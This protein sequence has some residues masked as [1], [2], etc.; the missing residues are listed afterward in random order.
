MKRIF[1]LAV[2][3]FASTSLFAQSVEITPLFGYTFS[4]HVNGYY[5]E[6]DVK[7]DIMYGA[8]LDVEFDHLI[9]FEASYRRVDTKMVEKLYLNGASTTV[10]IGIEHYQVGVIRDLKEGPVR[11]YAGILIGASRYFG[12]GKYNERYW[13]FST[14]VQLGAKIYLNDRIGFRFQSNLTLPMQFSGGGIFCG[15]GSG[16][17]GGVSFGVPLTHLDM[18]A[19]LIIRLAK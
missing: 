12:K 19:G 11:P 4:G 1:I 13:L 8:L 3:L 17:G 9:H 15:S 18:T 14:S 5:A 16:C 10:D 2:V 7:D 6:F